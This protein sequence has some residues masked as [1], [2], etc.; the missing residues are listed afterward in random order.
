[1]LRPFIPLVLPL[2]ARWVKQQEQ[3]ILREG[4]PLSP[5][6]SFDAHLVGVRNPSTVRLLAIDQIP[7]PGDPVLRRANTLVKL[8]APTTAG[9]TL[10]YGIYV[11]ED[12]RDD[13]QLVT[14]ELVHVAQ[15]ERYGAIH[16]FLRDY[17]NECLAPGYPNGPLEQEAIRKANEV[18]KA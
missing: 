10:G 13:R 1:M 12:L 8:V 3:R 9:I 14:H 4:V 15:Y 5:H 18:C 2:A 17:L 6:Q 7:L 11:R 16:A